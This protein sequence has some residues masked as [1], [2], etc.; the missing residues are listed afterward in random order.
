MKKMQC[1][2]DMLPHA[3]IPFE[4]LDHHPGKSIYITNLMKIFKN[5]METNAF[6]AKKCDVR[7]TSV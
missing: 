7:K 5:P 2:K 6:A 4:I 3:Q 1:Y